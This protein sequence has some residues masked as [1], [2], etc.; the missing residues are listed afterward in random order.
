MSSRLMLLLVIAA[1][2]LLFVLLAGGPTAGERPTTPRDFSKSERIGRS[3]QDS[4]NRI[5]RLHSR[6]DKRAANR[7]KFGTN[8]SA[9]AL[10]RRGQIVNIRQK[11]ED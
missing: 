4:R 5:A 3:G 11:Q 2:V 9:M 1:L 7:P 10:S 6:S 8:A